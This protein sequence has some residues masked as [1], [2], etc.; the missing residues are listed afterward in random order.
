MKTVHVDFDIA[1]WM[2]DLPAVRA[3]HAWMNHEVWGAVLGLLLITSLVIGTAPGDPVMLPFRQRL[4]LLQRMRDGRLVRLRSV[5]CRYGIAILRSQPAG[6]VEDS[7]KRSSPSRAR[8]M[9]RSLVGRVLRRV[10]RSPK[11][12][13]E[14]WCSARREHAAAY[15][16]F[17]RSY[18]IPFE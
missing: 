6:R 3:S 12:R 13:P 17:R 18:E 11:S 16:A 15:S 14:R 7:Q 5:L 2:P 8:N 1:H 10:F 9:R 4:E